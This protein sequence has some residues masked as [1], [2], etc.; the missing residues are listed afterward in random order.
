MA[1]AGELEGL[2]LRCALLSR[3]LLLTLILLWRVLFRPYDT[4]ASLNP[5]C[6]SSAGGSGRSLPSGPI[7][8][9]RVG[10]AIEASV[11]WDGVYFVRIAEC[12]Y[13]YEQTY[14]FYPLLPLCIS[15]LSRSGEL[16]CALFFSKFSLD[17]RVLALVRVFL[18]FLFPSCFA[19]LDAVFAPLVP[20]IG[21]RAVL[22]LS[23]YA[24]NNF[25]FL[26]AAVYFYR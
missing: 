17:L 22:A 8:W 26:F 1:K 19:F 21:Y 7:L 9:P 20:M 11:V 3:L 10:A 6:L 2:V 24:L 4:S 14:A 25:S 23:G 12:G 5:S 18:I 13:E 15:L 16:P